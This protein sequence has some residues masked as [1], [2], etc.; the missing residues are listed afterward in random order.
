MVA[1]QTNGQVDDIADPLAAAH[2]HLPAGRLGARGY[3]LPERVARHERVQAATNVAD[4]AGC[5]VV[6]GTAAKW[7]R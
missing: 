5:P 1:G 3:A 2:P 6:L 4:L 7:P